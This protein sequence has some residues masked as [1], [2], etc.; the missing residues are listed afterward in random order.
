MIRIVMRP[1]ARRSAAEFAD[2]LGCVDAKLADRFLDALE[3]SYDFLRRFPY[4]G[5]EW[6][7]SDPRLQPMRCWPVKGFPNHL[8]FFKV[9]ADRI[10]VIN[11]LYATRD[12]TTFFEG[13]T[14]SPREE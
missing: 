13:G 5:E 14:R 9:D 6:P 11:V 1:E 7:T 8:I 2:Y 10:D 3:E 4:S 12:L